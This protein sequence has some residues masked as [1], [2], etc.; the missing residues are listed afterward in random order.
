MAIVQFVLYT[1]NCS[2]TKLMFAM[3]YGTWMEFDRSGG[4]TPEKDCWWW[5]MFWNK[6]GDAVV[7]IVIGSW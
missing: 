2:E 6:C 1:I 4:R 7:C 5:L 3:T